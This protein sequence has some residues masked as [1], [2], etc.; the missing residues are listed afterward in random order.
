MQASPGKGAKE[1]KLKT[2]SENKLNPHVSHKGQA[3]EAS[4]E[5]SDV[6]AGPGA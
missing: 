1:A 3:D 4:L 6:A 2:A 5:H